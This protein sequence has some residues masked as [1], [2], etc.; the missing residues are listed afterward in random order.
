MTSLAAAEQSQNS[1][2]LKLVS[3]IPS[4]QEVHRRYARHQ[5]GHL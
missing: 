3:V 4:E 2:L 1:C 5:N